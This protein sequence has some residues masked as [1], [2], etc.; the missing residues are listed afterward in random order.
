MSM[1]LIWEASSGRGRLTTWTKVWRAPTAGFVVPYVVG[2]VE[3]E[4]GFDMLANVIGC[5]IED[6][7]TDMALTVEHHRI[8]GNFWL[9]YFGPAGSDSV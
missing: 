3:L 8:S 2:I 9:P 6:V 5:D 4:E 1:S 7:T